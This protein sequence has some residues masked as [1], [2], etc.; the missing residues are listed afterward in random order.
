VTYAEPWAEVVP[1]SARE[2]IQSD[3]KQSEI[4]GRIVIRYRSD[5]DA[6]HR[7][8]HRGKYFN[9]LG[10]IPDDESGK[11]HLTLMTAEGVNLG[12]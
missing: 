8:I 3:A 2:F 6:T 9:L 12:E 11:E 10:V 5:V 7:A 4:K 1:V